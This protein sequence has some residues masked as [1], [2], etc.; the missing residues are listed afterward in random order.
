[1]RIGVYLGNINPHDGGG[2]VFQHEILKGLQ[3]LDTAPHRFILFYRG[4]N[5]PMYN[6]QAVRIQRPQ[7][8]RLK[9]ALKRSLRKT[10]LTYVNHL[11][12][13]YKIDLVWFP[14][15]QFEPVDLPYI[16]TV[17]DLQHRLQPFFPE[18]SRNH[19]FESRENLYNSALKR[20]SFVLTG[21]DRGAQEISIFFQVHPERI[22]KLPH[23]VPS[24]ASL[25]PGSLSEI[26][27]IDIIGKYLFYP[28][29]F[30][31]HKNHIVILEAL[32]QLKKKDIKVPLVLVG[33]DKGTVNYLKN[34]IADSGLTGQV[35][36]LGFLSSELIAALYKHALALIYPTL[37]GPENLPP[38]EA[39]AMGCPAIVSEVPGSREQ[40][41]N[42]AAYFN[43]LS[44]ASLTEQI[45]KL[46]KNELWRQELIANGY[47]KASGYSAHR[48]INDLIKIIDEFSLY[49]RTWE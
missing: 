16:F 12:N 38:L 10:Y 40:Y 30:W 48:Y 18:V 43:P 14:T 34:K 35:Y 37:F 19:Q 3:A 20:A 4:T 21:T 2:F 5:A 23:P 8:F 46:M 39:F 22:R 33:S 25:Q 32:L 7:F 49:R 24:I 44:A 47:K 27:P 26:L 45:E 28:A 6:L 36:F 31:P 1:M 42:A 29:Q 13:E 11:L 17:W 9:S 15:Y 41:G